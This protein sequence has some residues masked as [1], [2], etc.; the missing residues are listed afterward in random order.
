MV[1]LDQRRNL[2][3]GVRQIATASRAALR[4]GETLQAF[5]EKNVSPALYAELGRAGLW[6][7][8]TVS[9]PYTDNTYKYVHVH[10]PQGE[11]RRIGRRIMSETEWRALDPDGFPGIRG[12]GWE[13]YAWHDPEPH[14]LLLR[15][16][17]QRK[18]DACIQT[19]EHDRGNSG[20]S[21]VVQQGG[22]SPW[23][24][25]PLDVKLAARGLSP[26]LY[27][28]QTPDI[29]ELCEGIERV[30]R[31]VA[32]H[33]LEA[34]AFAVARACIILRG[35]HGARGVSGAAEL[36]AGDSYT[37][38]LLSGGSATEVHPQQC[39][40]VLHKESQLM[41]GLGRSL[42]RD[43][44]CVED[45]SSPSWA[46]H[47]E[48]RHVAMSGRQFLVALATG[49]GSKGAARMLHRLFPIMCRWLQQGGA[50][51]WSDIDS[52]MLLQLTEGNLP[53]CTREGG[54]V[55]SAGPYASVSAA[56]GFMIWAMRSNRMPVVPLGEE[57]FLIA[58]AG[59]SDKAQE[60]M[61][62]AGADDDT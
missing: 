8:R 39:S 38:T 27:I 2:L 42:L 59:Q 54:V 21:K 57:S 23:S 31:A 50:S 32:E 10:L 1:P 60:Q 40:K 46:A 35:I 9:Q 53:L 19:A 37:S 33:P 49:D 17:R 47:R 5:C 48:K 7:V 45:E 20:G 11:A 29:L 30:A 24:D 14:I 43:H 51:P 4:P 62:R 26:K 22:A 36:L 3:E 58:F 16:L 13:H 6:P 44:G 61:R 41:G 55:N 56:F 28:H 25:L 34:Q 12:E 18:T 15:C 52:A